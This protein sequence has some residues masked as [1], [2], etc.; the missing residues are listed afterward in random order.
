MRTTERS[1]VEDIAIGTGVEWC[2]WLT[3]AIK[4]PYGA[5]DHV[6]GV[7]GAE[8]PGYCRWSL[9]TG[10]QNVGRKRL[11]QKASCKRRV[12]R[13]L[14]ASAQSRLCS[15]DCGDS[16][17][18]RS[19]STSLRGGF[20]CAQDAK[21]IWIRQ[22]DIDRYGAVVLTFSRVQNVKQG[23]GSAIRDR[24]S[25]SVEVPPAELCSAGQTRA[26]APTCVGRPRAAVPK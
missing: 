5:R 9:R 6:C 18:S 24:G 14:R 25:W 3:V 8:A 10:L 4:C 21:P 26:S 1:T 11:A 17:E 15:V 22:L 13:A 2:P 7:P 20:R 19:P 12:K 23:L 16:S